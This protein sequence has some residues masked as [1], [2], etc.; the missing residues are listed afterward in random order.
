M[1]STE[2]WRPV[3]GHETTHAISDHGRLKRF[4]YT[5]RTNHFRPESITVGTLTKAGYRQV[6]IK[7]K[8]R[9]LHSLVL[10]AFVGPCPA[11]MECCHGVQ[12]S[13]INHLTNLRYD[14]HSENNRDK[15]RHQT[16][17]LGE[18]HHNARLTEKQVIA[19]FL[20][21]RGPTPIAREL[22]V[23]PS[24]VLDIKKGRSW[25]WLTQSRLDPV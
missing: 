7:N 20:D 23:K 24:T 19:A 6:Q 1:H 25:G 21:T 22:G 10:R 5:D 8:S 15:Q 13:A 3:V 2:N 12:G 17:P 18:K 14:T 9:L 16:L 4:A 11:G